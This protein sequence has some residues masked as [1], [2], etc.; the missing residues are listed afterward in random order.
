MCWWGENNSWLD[1][2]YLYM[3]SFLNPF[4]NV[5]HFL[6]IIWRLNIEVLLHLTSSLHHCKS[7]A[8]LR[9]RTKKRIEFALSNSRFP[10]SSNLHGARR[11]RSTLPTSITHHWASVAPF[12]ALEWS[13]LKPEFADQKCENHYKINQL[14]PRDG[15]DGEGPKQF[16]KGIFDSL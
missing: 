11:T 13:A 16:K 15:K 5:L 12:I 6:L 8:D 3:A 1:F 2:M 7:I 10:N 4:D 9:M 14:C